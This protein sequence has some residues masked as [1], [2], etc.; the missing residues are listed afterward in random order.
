MQ[1]KLKSESSI[2]GGMQ[3]KRRLI[4]PAERA[5][6]SGWIRQAD[7]ERGAAREGAGVPW[8]LAQVPTLPS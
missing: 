8:G 7:G 6:A 2:F 4:F 5:P 1:Q 3:G